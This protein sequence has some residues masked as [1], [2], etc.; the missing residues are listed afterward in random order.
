MVLNDVFILKF[1]DYYDYKK[2]IY[3]CIKLKFDDLNELLYLINKINRLF[4]CFII[5]NKNE[6][7]KCLLFFRVLFK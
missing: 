5:L 2:D 3:I 7:V 4:L 1:N 6:D